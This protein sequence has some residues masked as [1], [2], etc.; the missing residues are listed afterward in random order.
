MP[1]EIESFEPVVDV[2][3]DDP[4]GSYEAIMSDGK[5]LIIKSEPILEPEPIETAEEA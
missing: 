1:S 4:W 2:N 5:E 3:D